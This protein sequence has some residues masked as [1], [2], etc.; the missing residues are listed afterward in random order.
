VREIERRGG[1]VSVDMFQATWISNW[2]TPIY[3]VAGAIAA[4]FILLSG[5]KLVR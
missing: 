3:G 4:L 2:L 1:D 5:V